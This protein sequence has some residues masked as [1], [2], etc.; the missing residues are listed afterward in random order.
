MRAKLTGLVAIAIAGCAISFGACRRD[1]APADA[2][3][4]LV[5]GFD[6]LDPTTVETLIG[7]GRLP[8][9]ARL[10]SEGAFGEL[11]V[12]PPLLSPVIWTTIAT[13]RS[14]LD[15]GIGHFTARDASGREIPVTSRMRRVPAIWNLFTTWRRSVGVV[16]WW[17]SWPP[18]KVRGV[19]VSDRVNYHL[20]DHRPSAAGAPEQGLVFPP[21]RQEE[22]LRRMVAPEAL[23][24]S[25]LR[26]FIAEPWLQELPAAEFSFQED[27][28]HLRWAVAAALSNRN[29]GLELWRADRPEL[30]MVYFEGTDSVSHLF[31]HL[32]RR[33]DLVGELEAQR[34]RF[35]GAVAAVYALADRILGE[36]MAELTPESTLIVLSDHGFRLGELPVDPSTTRDRRRVSD[37]Y[38]RDQGVLFIWGNGVRAA[39]RLRDPRPVDI[40]PTVASIFGEPLSRE[41]PGRPLREGFAALR[42]A[43]ST[44]TY[45]ARTDVLAAEGGQAAA[46]SPGESALLEQ[47]RSLGYLGAPGERS[48]SNDS[49]LAYIAL[50]ERRYRESAKAFSRLVAESPGEASLQTGLAS[51]LAGLGREAEARAAFAAAFEADPAFAPA[52]HNRAVFEEGLGHREA[53]LADYRQALR[54]RPDDEA[55]RDALVRLG[56]ESALAAGPGNAADPQADARLRAGNEALHRGD[57]TTAR[58]QFEKA[59][60]LAP[61]S[62]APLH[63][64]ANA[65]YLRGDR[66]EAIRNLTAALALEPDNALFRANLDRLK[67][68]DKPA[69]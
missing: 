22:L 15:H 35:G 38:H 29:L 33:N 53:A 16:G 54:Y 11:R 69:P 19:V 40:L 4:V 51:A 21:H 10:R 61:L 17:A 49:N 8:H 6:G 63:G 55:S 46:G 47:L 7:E 67:G 5:L 24:T 18:E 57:Y 42:E 32:H 50:R 44:P 12:D 66:D 56:G 64:L 36:F 34:Q 30:L 14:P 65:A 9:F 45:G 20:L 60:Q 59:R 2:P 28:S 23:P 1:Q 3:R 39:S 37:R 25:E 48:S 58:E 52:F 62:A 41:L 27:L 26:G 43:S 68:R 13:G 31:G